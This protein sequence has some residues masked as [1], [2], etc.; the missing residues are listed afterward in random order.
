MAYSRYETNETGQEVVRDHYTVCRLFNASYTVDV[1]T[2]GTSQTVNSRRLDLNVVD[3][4]D[5]NAEY[6]PDLIVQHAYSAFMVSQ[7]W[8]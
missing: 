5:A 7:I 8:L 3:Y 1:I 2:N 6:S 4:P